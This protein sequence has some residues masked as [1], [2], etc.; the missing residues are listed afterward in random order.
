MLHRA[1]SLLNVKGGVTE[2]ADQWCIEGIA[3][4][5]TP[6]RMGD[7]VEPLGARFKTPMPL[8]WQHNA[9][10]PVGRVEFA[11]PTKT[12]IPYSAALPKVTEAGALKDRIDEAVQSIKYRLVAAV[13]I[14]FSPLEGGFEVMK[15]GGLRFLEWEWLELSLVTI[16]ANADASITSIKAADFSA[17]AALGLTRKGI[18]LALSLP[19]ASG[20]TT[21]AARRGAVQLIPKASQ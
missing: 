4:T 9:Q 8:L 16:P 6:D 11:R 20:A 21:T 1:Y 7:V 15:A 10:K 12:G 3:S 17:R 19:G 2:A 14:G 18:P 13:S 5:P